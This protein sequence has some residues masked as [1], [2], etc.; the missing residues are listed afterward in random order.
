M[1]Y[2]L[3]RPIISTVRGVE[4]Q[5]DP[6]SICCIFNIAPIGLRVYESKSWPAVL[7]F[8]PKEAIQIMCGLANAKEMGKPSV[9]SLTVIIRV[10]H[11]MICSILLP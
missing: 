5:L 10:I 6:K 8:E 11:H 3:G 4:I 9:H 7:G 1:T 2:R